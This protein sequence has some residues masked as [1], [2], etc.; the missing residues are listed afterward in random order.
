[1]Q[2]TY[3]MLADFSEQHKK[4]EME[5]GRTAESITAQEFVTAANIW[6]CTVTQIPVPY[7]GLLYKALMQLRAP[8]KLW[9]DGSL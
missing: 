5:K 8:S 7:N 9:M 1:M 3:K 2:A 6:D 4:K